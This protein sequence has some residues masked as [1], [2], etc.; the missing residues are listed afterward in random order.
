VLEEIFRLFAFSTASKTFKLL[1]QTRLMAALMPKLDHYVKHSGKEQSPLWTLLDALDALER[2]ADEPFSNGLH[3]A[4]LAY[5]IFQAAVA[6]SAGSAGRNANHLDLAE[7]CLADFNNRFKVPKAVLFHAVHLLD[8]QQRLDA[9]PAPGRRIRPG[10]ASE[11][12]DALRL[13]RIRLAAAGG[14]VAVVDAWQRLMP[15][16]PGQGPARHG[17]P[18]PH[19]DA[20]REETRATTLP[21]DAGDTARPPDGA[22]APAHP[23][24][25]TEEAAPG[26]AARKRR[27]R[28]GGRRHRHPSDEGGTSAA[29]AAPPPAGTE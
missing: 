21:A 1:W 3:L 26:S 2:Q 23:A 11:F 16:A 7:Q 9:L 10:R 20:P 8:D 19:P 13:A 18:G 25:G 5:P 12:A 22:E 6:Q 28:R 15:E 4:V 14:S 17:R 24:G 29:P 27:R